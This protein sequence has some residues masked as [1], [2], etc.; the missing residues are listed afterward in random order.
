MNHDVTLFKNVTMH[1]GGKLQ[2]RAGFFNVFNMAYATTATAT[3]IDLALETTCSRR[4]DHVPNGLGDYA[5]GVCDPAGGYVFTP[6][7]IENFGRINLKRGHRV[8]ELAV[9]YMF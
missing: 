3:D 2:F 4:V 9:K 8:I 1:G 6:T 7:T 5:D